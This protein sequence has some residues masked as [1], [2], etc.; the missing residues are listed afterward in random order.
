LQ[1]DEWT[2]LGRPGGPPLTSRLIFPIDRLLQN[3]QVTCHPL[4]VICNPDILCAVHVCVC[5]SGLACVCALWAGED[6]SDVVLDLHGRPA[7]NYYINSV[8]QS[9]I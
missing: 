6:A 4:D 5:L 2:F 9:K 8:A 7:R 3:W 1:V